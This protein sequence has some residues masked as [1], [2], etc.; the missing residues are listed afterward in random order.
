MTS[1]ESVDV[2]AWVGEYLVVTPMK[3]G[4]N[5]SVLI[6]VNLLVGIESV[7]VFGP[8]RI[9]IASPPL[10]VTVVVTFKSATPSTVAGQMTFK[11]RVGVA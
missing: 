6:I 3:S 1:E 5:P 9:L 2:A 10:L 7:I 8:L 11:E 4:L